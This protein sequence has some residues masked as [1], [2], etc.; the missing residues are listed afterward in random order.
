VPCTRRKITTTATVTVTATTA[1]T[2]TPTMT[3]AKTAGKQVDN[4]ATECV[5]DLTFIGLSV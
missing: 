5:R 2:A 4:Y 3:K 1:T